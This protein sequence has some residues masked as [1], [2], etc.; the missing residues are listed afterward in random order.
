MQ[1]NDPEIYN[2]VAEC[3]AEALGLEPEEVEYDALVIDELGAESLDLLDIVFRLERAFKIKIPRG[4][5]ESAAKDGLADD[6]E[7]EVDGVL[8]TLGLERLAVAMP[9]IPSASFHEGLKVS[10]IPLLFRVSTFCRLV[11]ELVESRDA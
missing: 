1:P 10:E 11:V 5:I 9:E 8:T 7:Y 4:G 6:E 3:F 2:V